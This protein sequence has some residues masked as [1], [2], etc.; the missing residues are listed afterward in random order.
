MSAANLEPK[1]SRMDYFHNGPNLEGNILTLQLNV[2]ELLKDLAV[3]HHGL[4]YLEQEGVVARLEEMICSVDS[5]P[6]V[7]LL[8]PGKCY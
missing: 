8:L 7:G 6:L 1:S 2:L 4:V 5:N 3:T